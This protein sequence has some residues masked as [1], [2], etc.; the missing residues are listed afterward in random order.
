MHETRLRAWIRELAAGPRQAFPGKGVVK[1]EPV[2]PSYSLRIARGALLA[3]TCAAGA[4]EAADPPAAPSAASAS[5][6]RAS[7]RVE[8]CDYPEYPVIAM[9]DGAQGAVKMRL[10]LDVDGRVIAADVLKGAG[11]TRAHQIL[12]K[13]AVQAFVKCK[14]EPGEPGRFVDIGYVFSIR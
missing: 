6:H 1:P 3:A 13:S 5:K 9:R 14:F 12:N 8:H 10:Q 7:A 4:N 11:E 2:V